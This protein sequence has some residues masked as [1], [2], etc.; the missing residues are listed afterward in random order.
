M[1]SDMLLSFFLFQPKL[2]ESYNLLLK[3]KLGFPS[4]IPLQKG[5]C[6]GDMLMNLSNFFSVSNL[7]LTK[8]LLGSFVFFPSKKII[9]SDH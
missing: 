1:Y 3:Y 5:F 8:Y 2:L 6:C 4:V 9:S 7:S